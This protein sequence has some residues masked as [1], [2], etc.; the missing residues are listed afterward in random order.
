M[1]WSFPR[2]PS[3]AL[4]LSIAF[5][6]SVA[7]VAVA[8]LS[9]Q[10]ILVQRFA[11]FITESSLKGQTNDIAEAIEVDPVDGT[12]AVRL[13]RANAEVFDAFFANLKYRVLDKNGR[14]VAASDDRRD[15]LMQCMIS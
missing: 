9:I 5:A 6:L 2:T 15:S 1:R 7:I 12:V 14:V 10:A 3:L 11:S 8:Y 13:A 4:R